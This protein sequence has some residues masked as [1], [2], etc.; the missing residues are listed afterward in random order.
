MTFLQDAQ[1]ILSDT[2][3]SLRDLIERALSSQHYS[4]VAV[5]ARIADAIAH[6]R[7]GDGDESGTSADSRSQDG[8]NDSEPDREQVS[9]TSSKSS[10]G[11]RAKAA[12]FPRFE[13]D[14]DKLVKIGWSKRDER[15]Y[16]HRAPREI[17]FMVSIAISTKVKPNAVFTMDQVLPV[18]D[19]AGNEVPS[20][21]AYLA[22]AWLRSIGLVQRRGKEGYA[23]T[24]GALDASKLQ[25]LWTSIR[26]RH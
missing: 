11:R 3:L 16:E 15:V 24:N 5:V 10:R 4:D 2:E 8:P 21:Q 7:R 13:R 12:E 14:G 19:S 1:R 9:K 26:D 18:T 23:L 25:R 6:L 22:L 17:V 20:Y